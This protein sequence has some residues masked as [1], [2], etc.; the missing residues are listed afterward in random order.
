MTITELKYIVALAKEQHFGRAAQS[1]FVSQ[2]TLSIG[3][4]KLEEELGVQIFERL[5]NKVMP[6]QA[7]LRIIEAARDTLMSTDVIRAIAKE[8]QGDCIGDIKLGAIYTICPYLLPKMIADLQQ[9]NSNIRLFIEENYTA[10]LVN[11]LKDG[12]LDV[13]LLSLPIVESNLFEIKPIFAENFFVIMPKN[14]PLEKYKTIAARQL[15]NQRLFLLGSGNCFRD[16]VLQACPN[17]L[18]GNGLGSG[19]H[20]IQGGSLATIQMMVAGG[21]GISVFPQMAVA[22]HPDISIRP[23]ARPVPKRQI[24]LA[25][26]KSF[27]HKSVIEAI[28]ASLLRCHKNHMLFT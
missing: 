1:V 24:A 26:R 19:S 28:E 14:H 23:F 12:S 5:S 25:W 18:S 16:Q 3:I 10:E 20:L 13:V 21:L 22:D 27:T 2:P 11:Q 15:E 6:T 9:Q 4:K 7:G 17:C 8:V